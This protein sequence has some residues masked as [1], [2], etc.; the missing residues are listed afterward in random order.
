MKKLKLADYKN[1]VRKIDEIKDQKE[2]RSLLRHLCRTDLFFLIWYGLN[3]KDIFHSWLLERCQ[4]VQEKPNGYLDLW[5][6][7]HYKTAII[8]FGK[9]IQDILS[10]HGDDPLQHWNGRE[11]TIGIFSCTRPLAKRVLRQIKYEA[12]HNNVLKELFPDIFWE[13]PHKEAPKW[14]E[15][16]GIVFK[17]KSNPAEATVEAW[18]VVDGQPTRS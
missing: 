18:G 14:S 11:V 13:N 10:S 2:K 16:D 15:D 5:A 4:E 7:E 12:E 17:R 3:R 9:S 1:L 8:S 6:R